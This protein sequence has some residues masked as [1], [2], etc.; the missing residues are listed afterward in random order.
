ME[1]PLD[2]EFEPLALC[3]ACNKIWTL[4][5]EWEMRAKVAIHCQAKGRQMQHVCPACEQL[6]KI[7]IVIRAKRW[8]TKWSKIKRR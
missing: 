1:T 6:K 3:P 5:A 8:P 4:P 2:L 7:N